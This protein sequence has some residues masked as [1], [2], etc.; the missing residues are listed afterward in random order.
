MYVALLMWVGS[1]HYI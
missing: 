1:H